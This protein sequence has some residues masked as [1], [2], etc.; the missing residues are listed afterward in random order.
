[1][2][3]R[4]FGQGG[5]KQG[6]APYRDSVL[7]S[8]LADSLGGNSRTTMLAALSP[9]AV[10]YEEP[11][12]PRAAPPPSEA[13]PPACIDRV[14]GRSGWGRLLQQ[15]NMKLFLCKACQ[16]FPLAMQPRLP[17]LASRAIRP[18]VAWWPE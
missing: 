10:N 17:K 9:A 15:G 7:T 12:A 8:L 6:P 1:M 18:S 14:N 13:G 16:T 3:L 4:G 2:C 5:T 11:R